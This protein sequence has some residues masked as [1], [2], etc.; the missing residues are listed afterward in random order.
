MRV[1]N[2]AIALL[3]LACGAAEA[4]SSLVIASMYHEDRFVATGAR[5][6]PTKMA[7]AHKTLPFGTWLTIKHGRRSAVI[8]INDR[9]P[10]VRGRTL[11]LTPAANK[12]LLCYGMCRVKMESWPPL[13]KPRPVISEPEM[14]SKSGQRPEQ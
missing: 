9:G 5:F 4:G 10:Y 7:A 6:D 3:L 8:V 1:T 14:E 13:P 12:A 2:L 11:D